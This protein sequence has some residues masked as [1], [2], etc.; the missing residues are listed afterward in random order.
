MNSEQLMEQFRAL[1]PATV[2]AAAS[3]AAAAKG[4]SPQEGE[5]GFRD[6]AAGVLESVLPFV[7]MPERLAE[8][9]AEG[10]ME[11][12]MIG[13]A[14]GFTFAQ[15][16][17]IGALGEEL[18][19]RV[20]GNDDQ[21]YGERRDRYNTAI[22]ENS[23]L[24]GEI[25]GSIAGAPRLA[26]NAADKAIRQLP[27]VGEMLLA[28]GAA[29]LGARATATG[30]MGAAETAVYSLSE[31]KTLDA[32]GSDAIY[33]AIF[34]AG[35]Q[36]GA[37]GVGAV[38]KM[39]GRT[40]G[41]G[42]DTRTSEGLVNLFRDSYGDQFVTKT[43]GRDTLDAPAIAA[44]MQRSDETLTEVFPDALVN[45][46]N[47]LSG[48][49]NTKV[50]AATRGMM[51]H[52][53]NLKNTA[54]PD[55]QAAIGQA[56]GSATVR[57]QQEV[58]N[59][60]MAL[61][62]T[63][64]PLYTAALQNVARFPSGRVKGVKV[65]DVRK[66][67]TA[68]F[69]GA[70]GGIPEAAQRRLLSLLPSDMRGKQPRQFTPKQL[71]ELRQSLDGMIYKGEFP[72]AGQFDSTASIDRT[73]LRNYLTPA[74]NRVK[75]ML[76]QVA[77]DLKDIDA[78]YSDEISLRHAYEAGISAFKAKDGSAALDTF[79]LKKGRTP[80]E[81][82]NFIEGVKIQLIQD[83]EGKASAASVKNY[84]TTAA[85]KGKLKLIEQVAGPNA[86]AE[87]QNQA[88]RYAMVNQ[89]TKGVNNNMPSIFSEA[90]RG[91]GG[92]TDAA[93][94]A[95]AAGNVLSKSLG[96]GAAR[97]GLAQFGNRGTGAAAEAGVMSDLLTAP[98]DQAA[99]MVNENLMQSIPQSFRLLP[100]VA[101]LAANED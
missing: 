2:E 21:T 37:E 13:A 35:G 92:L 7:G 84:F 12:G 5:G 26:Y 91:L 93:L 100:G 42:A 71:L 76:Y 51:N 16:G 97:R 81:V 44:A 77:P 54:L 78:K 39:L 85:A 56:L 101:P 1:D 27:R 10:M 53:E 61:R 22:N 65:R 67:L 63:L 88:A 52:F 45:T 50:A 89:I 33:G 19:A 14:K 66:E 8:N 47:K 59:E 43:F 72:A 31:G 3:K 9:P 17:N 20:R 73:V 6:K 69:R 68:A 58:L 99:R 34:G 75:D 96:F 90:D 40:F 28:R 55:F 15:M 70:S 64:Q 36:L 80:G 29:G 95:G 86:A 32:A 23:N 74:R 30:A 24:G 83:L 48:T 60:G 79:V 87:L 4:S 49:Q 18:A 11:R 94:A 46:V 98:A 41:T 62:E 82:A 25:V 38:A 57:T